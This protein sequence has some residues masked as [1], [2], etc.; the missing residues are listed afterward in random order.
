MDVRFFRRLTETVIPDNAV[1]LF[2]FKA[3][4]PTHS[5][6]CKGFHNAE[7]GQ[8]DKLGGMSGFGNRLLQGICALVWVLSGIGMA[9]T[10]WAEQTIHQ[11]QPVIGLNPLSALTAIFEEPQDA[12]LPPD[13]AFQV[14]AD[15]PTGEVLIVDWRIAPGTY[16]YQDKLAVSEQSDSV[17]F[18]AYQLP[19]AEIKQD[20]VK[21]DGT[22]GDVAVYHDAVRLVIPL[23]YSDPSENQLQ[24]EVAYQG[25][26][27]RGICYPPQSRRFTVALPARQAH[28]VSS[29]PPPLVS[30]SEASSSNTATWLQ[31]LQTAQWGWALL[32]SLGLGVLVAFTACMYPMIPI[33]SSLILGQ[34]TVATPGRVFR[35]SLAYTQ[36]IAL[37]FGVLGAVMAWLGQAIGI[38]ASLQTPWVLIPSVVLFIVLALSMFGLYNIQ[39]PSAWQSRLNALSNTQQGGSVWG[40][41][42]MGVLSALIVGPCGGPILLAVLAFAAQAQDPFS[43]FVIVWLFGSG[44]G[45]PLLLMGVSGGALLPRAGQWMDQVKAAG[46]VILFALAISFLERL[47]PSYIDT[48]WIML[49][50][51]SLLIVVAVYLGA[52][53]TAPKRGWQTLAQGFGI[54]LLIYGALFL[55]GAAAGGKDTW[56]PL[57][58]LGHSSMAERSAQPLFQRVKSVS[59]LQQALAEARAAGRPV[60]LDFYADWCT[61]CKTMEHQVFP[62]LQQELRHFVWLQADITRQ[63][64]DDRALAQHLQ[65]IAPPAIY[66]WN[67]DG[68]AELAYQLVGE[69][70][71]AEIRTSAKAISK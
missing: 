46:G 63:D 38:Q 16:L 21:P 40:V 51:G 2:I 68:V 8:K 6:L 65:M 45:L 60:M 4:N 48:A 22:L 61:Y 24:I 47:S 14:A 71:V 17:S 58:G 15:S 20:S 50:W 34:G 62:A 18:G 41:G 11:T 70:G 49:A 7:D 28:V 29:T 19:V 67:A 52:V 1:F 69:V 31:Q 42:L 35:L 10:A 23:I 12:I 26:A 30:S 33:L 36:G 53:S 9:Q 57:R 13:Q 44:M 64:A 5:E 66:F 25:C 56:Q 37:T 43:G 55:Y 54:V 39:I 27:D 59:D 32:L 3:W